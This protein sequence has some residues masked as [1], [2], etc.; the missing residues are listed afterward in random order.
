MINGHH[1]LKVSAMMLK[2]ALEPIVQC[3]ASERMQTTH[4]E[5]CVLGLSLSLNSCCAS[6]RT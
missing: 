2:N 3:P 4:F 5:N 6:M 1:L